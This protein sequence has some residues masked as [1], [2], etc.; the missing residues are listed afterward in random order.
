[1]ETAQLDFHKHASILSKDSCLSNIFTIKSFSEQKANE[2]KKKKK[3][4]SLI[5]RGT[6]I[7]LNAFWEDMDNFSA[8]E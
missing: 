2:Q 6:V 5:V 1:M 8:V 3:E 4:Y 7:R